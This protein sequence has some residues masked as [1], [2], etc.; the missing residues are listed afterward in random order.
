MNPSTK[1]E[2]KGTFHEV[3]GEVKKKTGQ[4]TNNPD[5]EAD[6][7]AENNAGK[8]EKR[9]GRSKKCSRSKWC[10]L[11]LEHVRAFRDTY[12]Q[13]RFPLS[14]AG[15]R[16]RTA[17]INSHASGNKFRNKKIRGYDMQEEDRENDDNEWSRC[18]ELSKSG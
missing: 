15:R 12:M 16:R 4:V 17:Y 3:K 1:D 6:G 8:V 2:I 13:H 7:R 10:G 18:V 9:S 11:R 5:L 14:T